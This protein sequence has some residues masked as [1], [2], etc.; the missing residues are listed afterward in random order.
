MMLSFPTVVALLSSSSPVVASLHPAAGASLHS[1][2]LTR[3]GESTQSCWGVIPVIIHP[4]S[5]HGATEPPHAGISWEQRGVSWGSYYRAT[6]DVTDA[7]RRARL[8]LGVQ[9][10]RAELVEAVGHRVLAHRRLDVGRELVQAVV[11]EE[12]P[13]QVGLHG[14]QRV[15]SVFVQ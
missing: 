13:G 5:G 1:L 11:K 4:W 3:F 15:S 9:V 2:T 10:A 6:Q 8:Q 7:M 12:R 14:N